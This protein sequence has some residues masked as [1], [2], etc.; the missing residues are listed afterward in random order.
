MF[1]ANIQRGLF[2]RPPSLFF[3]RLV[4]TAGS[5]RPETARGRL[6]VRWGDIPFVLVGNAWWRRRHPS[7]TSS[8]GRQ[9]ASGVPDDRDETGQET[10]REQSSRRLSRRNPAGLSAAN[11]KGKLADRI[12]G[13]SSPAE[14]FPGETQKGSWQR[15]RRR[16]VSGEARAMKGAKARKTTGRVMA[17]WKK[18]ATVVGRGR[19]LRSSSN[20]RRPAQSRA[21]RA[22]PL[23]GCSHQGATRRTLAKGVHGPH[24]PE[25]S[26]RPSR[27]RGEGGACSGRIFVDRRSLLLTYRSHSG[28]F[29]RSFFASVDVIGLQAECRC[30]D[31]QCVAAR[32]VEGRDSCN[33]PPSL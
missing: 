3:L 16:R 27:K 23:L 20:V 1:P 12:P 33:A 31:L 8:T 5:Q 17:Q 6:S 11:A 30:S 25:S 9:P 32:K 28:R 26:G 19:L 10:R 7:T 15:R 18:T 2:R 4:Q 24:A 14:D 22:W 29:Y 21:C 13:E